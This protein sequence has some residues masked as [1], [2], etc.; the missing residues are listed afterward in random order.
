MTRFRLNWGKW[1]GDVQDC[2]TKLEHGGRE[3]NDVYRL[4]GRDD[5]SVPY[6]RSLCSQTVGRLGTYILRAEHKATLAGNRYSR[7]QLQLRE[8]RDRALEQVEQFNA[9]ARLL[10]EDPL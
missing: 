7:L 9:A 2:I 3:A 5:L 1:K 6:K 8:A 4:L 10:S